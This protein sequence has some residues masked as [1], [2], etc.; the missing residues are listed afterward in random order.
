[1]SALEIEMSTTVYDKCPTAENLKTR[2][3]FFFDALTRY[4]NLRKS[5]KISDRY[6]KWFGVPKPIW[7]SVKKKKNSGRGQW[8]M[9]P[10]SGWPGLEF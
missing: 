2:Q 7:V 4:K 8:Q 3:K 1:M 9:P 6:P 5:H 10:P